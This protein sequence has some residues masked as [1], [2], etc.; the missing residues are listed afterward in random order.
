[1]VRVEPGSEPYH[2][3]RATPQRL[4]ERKAAISDSLYHRFGGQKKLGFT[5]V[6]FYKASCYTHSG[7]A[8]VY[9]AKVKGRALKTPYQHII[10]AHC[11]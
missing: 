9:E 5:L 8:G 6:V 1:M 10:G 11:G 4:L 3:E 7:E 2:E